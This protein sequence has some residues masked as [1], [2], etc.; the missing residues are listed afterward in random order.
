MFDKVVI[1]AVNIPFYCRS[2]SNCIYYRRIKAIN[3]LS[4]LKKMKNSK[5][6]N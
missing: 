5:V 2:E 3:G 4:I 1:A 6:G